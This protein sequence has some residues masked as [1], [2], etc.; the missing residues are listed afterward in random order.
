[1]R[2]FSL[3]ALLMMSFS[4]FAQRTLNE[5]DV[6]T[7]TQLDYDID[8]YENWVIPNN[9][10]DQALIAFT[11]KCTTEIPKL[12]LDRVARN[13][14]STEHFQLSTKINTFIIRG[15]GKS[16]R[17]RMT[18]KMAYPDEYIFNFEY[19]KIIRQEPETACVQI[20]RDLDQSPERSAQL[21]DRRIYYE[22]DAGRYENEFTACQVLQIKVAVRP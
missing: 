6:F 17:C 1:M 3:I 19:S 4:S 9:Q 14:L 15:Y 7:K 8:G 21:F 12:V 13:G 22:L 5:N 18:V 2:I 20:V 10:R 11:E 16:Y